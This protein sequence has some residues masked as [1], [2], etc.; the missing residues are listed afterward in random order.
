M[1]SRV[2]EGYLS[3]VYIGTKGNVQPLCFDSHGP[4]TTEADSGS[5]TLESCRKGAD[6]S[7]HLLASLLSQLK[8]VSLRWMLEA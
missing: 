2:T 5:V 6:S 1:F 3:L 8:A 4:W 7:Q